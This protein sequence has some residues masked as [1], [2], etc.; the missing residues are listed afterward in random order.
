MAL[1]DNEIRKMIDNGEFGIRPYIEENIKAASIDLTLGNELGILK[2]GYTRTIDPADDLTKEYEKIVIN[3]E[4]YELD[5][6][7]FVLG[8]VNEYLRLPATV[9]GLLLNRSTPARMGLSVNLASYVNPGYEGTLPLTIKNMSNTRIKLVPG[10]R[11]CQITLHKI[12]GE[13]S[14]EYGQQKDAKYHK[15]QGVNPPKWHLDREIRDFFNKNN[16]SQ[17]QENQM[18]QL[19]A[20][21]NVKIKLTAEKIVGRY[22]EQVGL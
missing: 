3:D 22:K 9:S 8:Y 1:S 15:E 4:G 6:N 18:S 12:V 17:I 11:I 19:E 20:F 5:P 7:E 13:V 14:L 16:N 2:E 21:L 10:I